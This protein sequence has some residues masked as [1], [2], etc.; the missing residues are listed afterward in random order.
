ML[1]LRVSTHE[2]AL[3]ITYKL[4]KVITHIYTKMYLVTSQV[5]A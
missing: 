2:P 5:D 3:I 1:S 4:V